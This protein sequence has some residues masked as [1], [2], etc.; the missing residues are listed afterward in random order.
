[1]EAYTGLGQGNPPPIVNV[2]G[3]D[4]LAKEIIDLST[5]KKRVEKIKQEGRIWI[6]KFYNP[7]YLCRLW[8]ERYFK[9]AKGEK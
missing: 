3:I 5:D 9:I 6:E 2:S 4:E 7:K 1:L 8:E